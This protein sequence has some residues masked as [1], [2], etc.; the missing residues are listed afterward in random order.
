VIEKCLAYLK[1]LR[2]LGRQIPFF[3]GSKLNLAWIRVIYL[4][5]I[6]FVSNFLVEIL[7]DAW[8]GNYV[9]GALGIAG[10]LESGSLQ[11]TFLFF[12]VF[13]FFEFCVYH[14]ETRKRNAISHSEAIQETLL[15]RT[16]GDIE[17]ATDNQAARKTAVAANEVLKKLR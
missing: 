14:S 11:L 2:G 10:F 17:S 3:V 16:M 5:S 8:K 1:F 13:G 7:K 12:L 9:G 4:F 6:A 15:K